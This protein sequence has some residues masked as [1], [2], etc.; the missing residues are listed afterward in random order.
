MKTLIALSFCALIFLIGCINPAGAP[1]QDDPAI[2]VCM[3]KNSPLTTGAYQ[4]AGC[5]TDMLAAFII[6]GK[7]NEIDSLTILTDSPNPEKIFRKLELYSRKRMAVLAQASNISQATVFANLGKFDDRPDTIL[8]RGNLYKIGKDEVGLIDAAFSFRIGKVITKPEEDQPAIIYEDD[9][10]LKESDS[11]P[12][13]K[14]VAARI[15]NVEFIKSSINFDVSTSLEL[16]KGWCTAAIIMIGTNSSPNTTSD[17]G[18]I[19]ILLEKIRLNIKKNSELE[20]GKINFARMAVSEMT[21]DSAEYAETVE[22]NPSNQ[23]F[24]D[25]GNLHCLSNSYFVVNVEVLSPDPTGQDWIQVCFDNLDGDENTGNFTFR[26]G[27][28]GS[29][30]YE[31]KLPYAAISAGKIYGSDKQILTL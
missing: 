25:G 17:S 1:V 6:T 12:E 26:D 27:K 5:A 31:L 20:I 14:V 16:K 19:S 4:I 23:L 22:F 10:T 15:C 2:H 18:E 13:I 8:I 21:Y 29:P 9:P 28:E 3:D 30:K 7:E 24:W 11:S